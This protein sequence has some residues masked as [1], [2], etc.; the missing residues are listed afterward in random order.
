VCVPLRLTGTVVGVIVVWD[1]LGQKA[2]LEGVDF[3]IFNLLGA[4][5]ANALEAARLATG[6]G[7]PG[8]RFSNLAGLL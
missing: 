1:F 7:A 2:E 4:H 6:A 3:E 8:F 5:A